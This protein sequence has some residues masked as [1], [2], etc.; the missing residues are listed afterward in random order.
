MRV[1]K[2]G[3]SSYSLSGWRIEN[4][5][6]QTFWVFDLEG[7]GGNV[8]T[9][10]VTQLGAV[11]VSGGQVVPGSEFSQLVNPG[12]PIRPFMAELTGITDERVRDAP[13]FAEAFARFAAAGAGCVWVSHS[14]FEFDLPF[15]LAECARHGVT[16]PSAP[17]M[18]NRALHTHL[19][20]HKPGVFGT[21]YQLEHFGI[22]LG[23]RQRHDALGD[24]LLAADIFCANLKLCRERDIDRIEVG[25]PLTVQYGHLPE[26]APGLA[27]EVDW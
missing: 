21:R 23:N 9:E 5:H 6:A 26:A 24:A 7:T 11:K 10:R 4:L 15:L 8:A 1:E 20:P 14:A 16:L 12:V 2:N 18:D 3:E 17:W 22:D 25:E 13:T 19:H 27:Y